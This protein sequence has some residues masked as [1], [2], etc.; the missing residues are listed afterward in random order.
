[1]AAMRQFYPETQFISIAAN[2]C[3]R[4]LFSRLLA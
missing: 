1:M 4:Q 3:L 2:S